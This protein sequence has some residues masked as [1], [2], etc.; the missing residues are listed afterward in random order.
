MWSAFDWM[1]QVERNCSACRCCSC[2]FT[3]NNHFWWKSHN[4]LLLYFIV[5]FKCRLIRFIIPTQTMV[6]KKH[7]RCL[8]LVAYKPPRPCWQRQR[9]CLL[10]ALPLSSYPHFT[11]VVPYWK[12][13]NEKQDLCAEIAAE[14]SW[15]LIAVPFNSTSRAT[16]TWLL[17][18][19]I[20]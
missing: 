10:L 19:L 3:F 20:R 5:A 7:E 8:Q 16:A 9:N 6:V 4:I 15:R 18:N 14:I 2:G 13:E 1:R 12:N 17:K 11:V